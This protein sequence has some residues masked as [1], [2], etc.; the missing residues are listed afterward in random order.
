LKLAILNLWI[1]ISC[2][3][4]L[5]AVASIGSGCTSKLG[6]LLP[7]ERLCGLSQEGNCAPFRVEGVKGPIFDF[8]KLW[9]DG[10]GEGM[11]RADVAVLREVA[12]ELVE[13]EG[14]H[15]FELAL[16][17]VERPA[18]EP[19][20]VET[21]VDLLSEAR[22]EGEGGR[23]GEAA[24]DFRAAGDG[25]AGRLATFTGSVRGDVPIVARAEG[26]AA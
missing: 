21:C 6:P 25:D 4:L 13:A 3:T 14:L 19:L 7:E 22:G 23:L 17:E 5:V 2:T 20:R 8:N 11:L 18:A 1:G 10:L 12:A 15:I 26:D 9:E 16:D 24:T